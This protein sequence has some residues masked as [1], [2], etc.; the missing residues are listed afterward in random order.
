MPWQRDFQKTNSRDLVAIA[1]EDSLGPKGA[2]ARAILEY[3]SILWKRRLSVCFGVASLVIS[4]L[5][6]FA[7][8]PQALKVNSTSQCICNQSWGRVLGALDS[9]GTDG[10]MAE[11]PE[12]EPEPLEL[13][14]LS[15]IPE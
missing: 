11:P 14:P 4:G 9:V 15:A 6:V 2:A 12:G 3:R 13:E 1:I 10:T 8:W 7:T 5:L